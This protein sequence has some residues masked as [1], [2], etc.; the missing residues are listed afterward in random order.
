MWVCGGRSHSATAARPLSF[1]RDCLFVCLFEPFLLTAPLRP[2]SFLRRTA[3]HHTSHR[4]HLRPRPASRPAV[5]AERHPHVC[6]TAFVSTHNMFTWNLSCSR[7]CAEHW[8]AADRAAAPMLRQARGRKPP[9]LLSHLPVLS[10][11]LS[12]VLAHL[13]GH[14]LTCG[15]SWQC[16]VTA[17]KRTSKRA[18][19]NS[20]GWG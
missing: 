1:Q 9:P 8:A 6:A 15:T 11:T 17:V 10:A 7:Q 14:V 5:A 3:S 16:N 13:V 12:H 2:H 20:W 4:T 19:K 18:G